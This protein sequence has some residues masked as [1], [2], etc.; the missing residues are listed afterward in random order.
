MRGWEGACGADSGGVVVV[1]GGEGLL[2]LVLVLLLL[3]VSVLLLLFFAAESDLAFAVH[4]GFVAVRVEN[5]TGYVLDSVSTERDTATLQFPPDTCH[6]AYNFGVL[7]AALDSEAQ[8][9]DSM[10]TDI[11]VM[12]IVA[13]TSY[14]SFQT[15]VLADLVLDFAVL[16]DERGED[17]DGELLQIAPFEVTGFVLSILGVSERSFGFENLLRLLGREVRG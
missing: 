1:G 16:P 13:T 8:T 4:K 17:K 3:L 7:L 11:W 9:H 2:V 15:A 14:Q 5:L 6:P 12:L 10:L